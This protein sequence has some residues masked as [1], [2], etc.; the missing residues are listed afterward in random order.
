MAT[1]LANILMI[2]AKM[3]IHMNRMHIQVIIVYVDNTVN[4]K[5]G[6]VIFT[7][8]EELYNYVGN[9]VDI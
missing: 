5:P 3:N 9:N 1:N 6:R 8:S 2:Y 7:Y 4:K